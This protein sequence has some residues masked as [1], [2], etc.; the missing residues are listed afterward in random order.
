[1][2]RETK[3]GLLVGTAVILLIGIIV[4]DHLATVQR[5]NPAEMTRFADQ[6]Q[7]S[8]TDRLTTSRTAVPV[9][10]RPAAATTAQRREVLPIAE[11][12]PIKPR[13]ARAHPQPI[14]E[15]GPQVPLD[16]T[17]PQRG[18]LFAAL[19][20]TDIPTLSQTDTVSIPAVRPGS[21]TTYA[22]VTEPDATPDPRARTAM[23]PTG[24]YQQ[25]WSARQTSQ[26]QTT[27]A[28]YQTNTSRATASTVRHTV[29]GGESLWVIAQRY[30]GDGGRWREIAKAN[31]GEVGAGGVVQSGASLVIPGAPGSVNS[32]RVIEAGRLPY[33]P[34]T[35]ARTMQKQSQPE[36]VTPSAT[37][38]SRVI[39]VKAGDH[40]SSLARRHL[41]SDTRWPELFEANRD[42]LPDA[43]SLRPGMKLVLPQT[44]R[45]S[46]PPVESDR[47][48]KPAIKPATQTHTVRSS[49]T[50]SSIA[51]DVLGDEGKW[52]AIY[53]ANR[54]RLSSPNDIRPG[55]KLRIPAPMSSAD[56]R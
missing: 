43:D 12:L 54:D 53:Q 41:G 44:A 48:A 20:N 4:S 23:L 11:D 9:A 19:P 3:I 50:L 18:P 27:P 17:S 33:V 56:A 34:Q 46:A 52:Y 21:P 2:A 8:I 32:D 16:Q 40:L 22:P 51:R 31:P 37:D 28:R 35:A 36:Q 6:A 10:E 25:F 5:Q 29:A 39:L 42:Q 38:R 13:S 14:I 7:R 45:S 15:P 55:Q 47:S 30:Y 49:E 24:E 1:M 26:D